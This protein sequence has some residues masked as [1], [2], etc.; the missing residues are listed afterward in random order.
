MA[1][2]ARLIR[3][4]AVAS[5]CGSVWS[6][7]EKDIVTKNSPVS[8]PGG[9]SVFVSPVDNL[10]IRVAKGDHCT[11][12]VVESDVDGHR[13]GYLEP[14][15]FPCEFAADA[16]TYT[17]L[18]SRTAP[19][20]DRV[21]L[22]VR[23]DAKDETL[24][25]P[26]LLLVSTTQEPLEVVTEMQTLVVKKIGGE[27]HAIDENVLRFDAR[28][29]H[30]RV[31][32]TTEVHDWPKR[33]RLV[34]EVPVQLTP[35]NAFLNRDVRY[36]HTAGPQSVNKDFVPM[37]VEVSDDV[38]RVVKRERF[39]LPVD[40]PEGKTNSPPQPTFS[41]LLLLDVNQF[42]VTAVTPA[43][44][45]AEDSDSDPST[46]LFRLRTILGPEEGY[47]VTTDDRS[48]PITSFYQKDTQ[49]LK[50]AYVP[51]STSSNEK[52]VFRVEMEVAD[53]EGAKSDPFALMIVVKP[54]NMMAPRVTRN[55]GLFL[56]EGQTKKLG[57]TLEISDEDNRN[58]VM[59]EI[60]DGL[61][62][63]HLLL[64]GFESESFTVLDLD[65]G[66]VAYRHD[67]SSTSTDNIVFRISDGKLWSEFLYPVTIYPEDDEPPLLNVNT[68]LSVRK[69]EDLQITSR[70]LSAT[71][72]DSDDAR[73]VYELLPP[74]PEH[75]TLLLKQ[76]EKPPDS[77]RWT[78]QDE[79]YEREV[80]RWTQKDVQEG[81]VFYRHD[82]EH[83]SETVIDTIYFRLSDDN[84]P[85]NESG[86][87]EFVVK[88]APVDNVPPEKAPDAT[89]H[90]DVEEFQLT[91]ITKQELRYRD[92]DTKDK[93]LRYRITKVPYDIDENNPMNPGMVVRVDEPNAEV[94]EFT[95]AEVN[96]KKIAFKP[97]SIELGIVPRVIQFQFEVYDAGDNVLQG[98][99]FSVFL[100]PVDNKPP[101]ILNRGVTVEE[102]G[103][104]DIRSDV[105]DATD[106]DTPTAALSFRVSKPPAYGRLEVRTR[107]L[108]EDD[109]FTRDDI[110]NGSV[111]YV[112]T[113]G[114]N[115]RQD[116]I[117]LEVCDG[118]HRVPITLRV[119]IKPLVDDTPEYLPQ[120]GMS[121]VHLTVPESR[122]VEI[123]PHLFRALHREIEKDGFEFIIT[124]SPKQ[125]RVENGGV[126][127]SRFTREDMYKRRVF[128]VHSGSE[129]GERGATDDFHLSVVRKTGSR[130]VED[131][132]VHVEIEPVDSAPPRVSVGQPLPVLEGGKATITRT[133]LSATDVDSND[134]TILCNIDV[135]PTHGY[136]EN[137]S[138]SPG[139]ESIRAGVPVSSFT[140]SEINSGWVNYVQSI[141]R[142]F[143]PLGD[144]F[145]FICSDGINSSPNSKF[146]IRIHPTNDE[147]P[148]IV[149]SE[150]IV[151]EGGD[152]TIDLTNIQVRDLDV[153]EDKLI[154]EITKPPMRGSVLSAHAGS[155]MA[156]V[157]RFSVADIT[158]P[159][160]VIY[161]HDDSETEGDY[162][163]IR[164]SDGWQ[165]TN[166]RV[167]ITI[168]PVDDE[169]PRLA[170]NDGLEVDISETKTITNRLLRA[171][172]LDSEDS[173]L[174]YVVRQAP[175]QGFLLLL[176]SS[177]YK[178]QRNLTRGMNFTQRDIDMGLVTY[179]QTGIPGMRD[180]IKFDV[181]DGNN[182]LIDRRFWITVESLDTI[183]PEVVSRGVE[184]QEGGRVTLTTDI[185]STSDLNSDDER[186]RFIITRS[187]SKGHLES[188][189]HPGAV[190]R[191]FTQMDLAGSKICYVHT[192][193]DESKLDSFE[194]EVNDGRNSVF[195]MFRI[196]IKD[197]DNK[198]PVL[199]IN[200]LRVR[201]G[202]ERLITPFELKADD[203][204]TPESNI[205]FTI[206]QNAIHG[207]VL[208]RRSREVSF[209]TMAD[210]SDNRISYVHDGSETSKDNFSFVV[211]DGT[212]KDFFVHPDVQKATKAAQQFSI[213]V[214][215]VDNS[216]PQ[217]A[218]NKGAF[219]LGYL[220]N[221]RRLGFRFSKDVLRACDADTVDAKLKYV[222]TVFPT[223]GILVNRAVGNRS[224]VE[225]TQADIDNMDIMYVLHQKTNVTRDSFTFKVI[226][227]GKNELTD[228]K[229]ELRWAWISLATEFHM[230]NETETHFK[231]KLRRRGYLGETAFVGI[232][233]RNL[234]AKYG[235][236]YGGH[237]GRQ[238]QFNPGQ[239]E[240][241]W[242]LRIL[243]DT[244]YEGKEEFVIVLDQAF[245]SAT[246]FPEKA[247]VTIQDPEDEPRV[248]LPETNRTID[249]DEGHT[250]IPI[251][252]DGDLSVDMAVL[253]ITQ[254]GTAQG[255]SPS[256]IRSFSDYI[257]RPPDH[258]SLVR[259]RPGETDK[260]C[261]IVVIDDSLYEPAE[262]FTV[263]LMTPL[264]GKIE[265]NCRTEIT[266]LSD[267][268]DV[269]Y[270][271]FEEDSYHVG[272]DIGSF[273]VVVL[274]E[275]P[276]L[277]VS[278]SVMVRSK[279]TTPQSA[280]AGSDYIAVGH[281]MYFPPGSTMQTLEV[282]IL[283]DYGRPSLELLETFNLVL[284]VPVNGTLGNPN[285]SLVTINDTFSDLPKMYF[286]EPSYIVNEEA[287]QI[288]VP[289]MRTG[290]L[291]HASSVRCY[292]RQGTARV[293]LDFEERPNTDQ[294]LIV[295]S[296]GE[297]EKMCTLNIKDDSTL[298][299]KEELR[300]VLGTPR[301]ETAGSALVGD[302]N[303]TVICI[304][305]ES[306]R[307][308]LRFQ[309][310]RI[311]VKEPRS[312][313]EVFHLEV[314]IVRTGDLSGASVV[315]VYSRDGSAVSGEDYL[316]VSLEVTMY[317]HMN[318][319]SV[320]VQIMYDQLKEHREAFTLH[321]REDIHRIAEVKDPKVIVYIED[322]KLLPAV[323]FPSE[324][325]VVSLRNYDCPSEA[326]PNP[327][328]GYPLSCISACNMKHPDY[329]KTGPIC[330]KEGINDT[331]TEFRWKVA[332]PD[333]HH[334]LRDIKSRAF[335]APVNGITLDS[336]YFSVGSR[337]QCLTRAVNTD[338]DIGLEVESKPVV[339]SS[340][341]GLCRPAQD[342]YVGAEPFTAKLRY[343]G[344]SDPRSP[345]KIQITVLIPHRDGLLP[346]VST[347]PL[348]NF[349][350]ALGPNSLRVGLHKCSNLV[351]PS[352][353]F[354]SD[355]FLTDA[356]VDPHRYIGKAEPYQYS[357]DMRGLRTLRFYK[358]LDLESCLWNFTA[359]YTLSELV[360]QCG[361]AINHDGQALN[362][363][364]SYVSV[365]VPLYV[366]YILHSSAAVGGWQHSDMV[367]ELKISFVYNTA[368][369]WDHGISTPL[370][371]R[372]N[373]SIY[374]TGM[375]I[376]K[377]GQLVV[378]FRTV[379]GFHGQYILKHPE[380]KRVSHVTSVE[381]PDMTFTLRL[382]NSEKT[383]LE[384]QQE[385]EITSDVAVKD[386]S[387]TYKIN[388]IPCTVREETE[389]SEPLP[390]NPQEVVSFEL[391]IHFQQVSDPVPAQFTLNTQFHVTR[392]RDLWL[393]GDYSESSEDVDVS[394]VKGD[395]IYGRIRVNPLQSIGHSFIM[396]IEKCFLCTGVDGYIPKYDPENEE[397]GCIAESENIRYVIKIIDKE[398]P[399]TISK[400]FL[401][402]PFNATLLSED[403]SH[404]N[405]LGAKN[406]PG[407]DGFYFSADP[408]FKITSGTLWFIH[409]IYT[410]RA[411]DNGGYRHYGK[412]Q[413]TTREHA[414]FRRSVNPETIGKNGLGT[415]MH[416]LVLSNALR[417]T[418]TLESANFTEIH[419][420]IV[421]A[422]VGIAVLVLSCVFV[423]TILAVRRRKR[424]SASLTGRGPDSSTVTVTCSGGKSHVRATEYV[425]RDDTVAGTEV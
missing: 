314:P 29:G 368:I 298:E 208:Y 63:G 39:Q 414:V 111:K 50:I 182:A 273:E 130:N 270:F 101:K 173:M 126:K 192:S 377:M 402:V 168:I 38:G 184:L 53:E 216:A 214:L 158:P 151:L 102:N 282:I 337:V 329:L 325:V 42:I 93:D 241:F 362:L 22:L 305:D 421:S 131:V 310:T 206:T 311:T 120:Q 422:I 177:T 249:E 253:C 271:F 67:S 76:P 390:C 327:I 399:N 147:Q 328:P 291:K 285:T 294:S 9:R 170:V 411:K 57:N 34:G 222:V 245:M 286:L 274:R 306:D 195:R 77:F 397:Y 211:T 424:N 408:L 33:G 94:T 336:V 268:K 237:Y 145:S 6:L 356:I 26:I 384:P 345:N 281:L 7:T 117:E 267:P 88:V 220:D 272:E 79:L 201:E 194:F 125:G 5:L 19:L 338:R 319:T 388:L 346:A 378:R 178:P 61:R 75:G 59:F 64:D 91:E 122:K 1:R 210:L 367:T 163:E 230:V 187:P 105:L 369:L 162:F 127:I 223:H 261:R 236:D 232:S 2:Y 371:S 330:A 361:G 51:P 48:V 263:S 264:N 32:V 359:F 340:T 43:V 68:G 203:I 143:E 24:I 205:K 400:S 190:L 303:A 141:H 186:L 335:F 217:L 104:V 157:D 204:D 262:N 86:I 318:E 72:V 375:R 284:R 224:V 363:V 324:P 342:G 20:Q 417:R 118:I 10:R 296:P 420:P 200:R 423:V 107:S 108:E 349:E 169:T 387:G 114:G 396:V 348:S 279:P 380:R 82:G 295:F 215:P 133:Y 40:I 27:S 412:R 419:W 293:D 379:P 193:K 156:P 254:P 322:V 175:R 315:R 304:K 152:T 389:Y 87:N 35:C 266:I 136:V 58:D 289:I 373:G 331:F 74:F 124:Q 299:G 183:Y 354:T 44:L 385:W 250:M 164:V 251:R 383:F 219:A 115:R 159:S 62:Y 144:N 132:L 52:R 18:G 283:D 393:T 290:D 238:V 323:V 155:G 404:S 137:A 95:Q 228:Q 410:L 36:L 287:G 278:S 307:S 12:Q 403:P 415:N 47:F 252:R 66:L 309:R 46:L 8:V 191:S 255:S 260:T 343:T 405:L 357:K 321:M 123:T 197:V 231:I 142:G 401:D 121:T 185:L 341:D 56:L 198:K 81:N 242:K 225:F 17:H 247:L 160:S 14:S 406:E 365:T 280:E 418:S 240:A 259:F 90:L 140:I 409:C 413:T 248:F 209:F 213:E 376:N 188:T 174:T 55:Q 297:R 31:R 425:K 234:T 4:L 166:G 189:D 366:S 258:T 119:Q 179:T 21:R 89:L 394:F 358:N 153:P 98:Q 134:E 180:L 386:Y 60:V 364:Q 320:A 370:D 229:F 181:T 233:A 138:P 372:L 235:S 243:D 167:M 313:E 292:T 381:Q 96:H 334:N 347:R 392:R 25:V 269:P 109:V 148:E 83:V 15:S 257:S 49:A 146:S 226:D 395:K 110:H 161:R 221:S 351:E 353:T 227:E 339:V 246:E 69:G 103:H 276:D 171:E 165:H 54:M 312:P 244:V 135:Q 28:G 302:I 407:V 154:F 344:T 128:Y 332:P 23:Y 316:P 100:H 326:P 70:S 199:F 99:I 355:G 45:S 3:L 196:S 382:I 80:T 13:P 37:L 71:D 176:N 300:L 265:G 78:L 84:T 374:P 172:D 106:V 112:N 301:S 139:S 288:S 207:K 116:R 239:A 16:V 256:P 41:S 212:H 97:P 352:E 218:V 277:S 73:I 92:L 65:D 333:E 398:A 360:S 317:P 129:T 149:S 391:P 275:G 202:S 113:A 85:P 308:V 30:C 150:L 11:V 350:F 416:Q